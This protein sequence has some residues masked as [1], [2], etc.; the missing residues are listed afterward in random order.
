[1]VLQEE[2]GALAHLS[3]EM[4]VQAHCSP[5]D[6]QAVVLSET[7]RMGQHCVLS[8]SQEEQPKH[9]RLRGWG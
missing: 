2:E 4:R 1:M 6:S 7:A 8:K 3:P 5:Q 9:S